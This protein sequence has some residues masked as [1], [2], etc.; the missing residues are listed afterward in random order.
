MQAKNVGRGTSLEYFSPLGK[1][2]ASLGKAWVESTWWP[3]E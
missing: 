1:S 2:S 3:M